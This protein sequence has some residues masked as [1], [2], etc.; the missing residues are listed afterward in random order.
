[1]AIVPETQKKHTMIELTI[2][3][4]GTEGI[5]FSNM[6]EE[7]KDVLSDY[8]YPYVRSTIQTK[9][10]NRS[11]DA[12]LMTEDEIRAAFRYSGE[13]L[14]S[15]SSYTNIE[16]EKALANRDLIRAYMEPND[17]RVRAYLRSRC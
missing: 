4:T 16:I 8:G 17:T 3:T 13:R 1:V 11:V 9:E 6:I 14:G 7:L 15:H 5:N 12:S 10:L 2:D